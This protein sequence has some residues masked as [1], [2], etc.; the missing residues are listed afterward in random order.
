MTN[1]STNLSFPSS[2][3]D[4]SSCRKESQ[5]ISLGSLSIDD[6]VSAIEK[7]FS[8]TTASDTSSPGKTESKVTSLDYSSSL[9]ESAG[10]EMRT[11]MVFLMLV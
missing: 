9:V 10:L 6:D 2:Q 1:L 3:E 8:C 5:R 7:E 11:L 4:N